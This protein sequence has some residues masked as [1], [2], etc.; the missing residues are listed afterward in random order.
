MMYSLSLFLEVLSDTFLTN[1]WPQKLRSI[2][3]FDH[4]ILGPL[5]KVSSEPRGPYDLFR[6]KELP[7]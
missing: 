3:M 6:K 5:G 2:H 7:F 1:K 4:T